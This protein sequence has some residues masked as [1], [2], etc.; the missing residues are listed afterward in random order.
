MNRNEEKLVALIVAWFIVF[1][2]V[3]LF[4]A[5]IHWAYDT[6]FFNPFDLSTSV[7]RFSLVLSCV[8]NFIILI[9]VI[10]SE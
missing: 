4:I 9:T 1:S 7:A 6:T 10:S 5:A 8:F 3:Y 2:L